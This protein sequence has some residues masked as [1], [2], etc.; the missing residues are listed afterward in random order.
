MEALKLATLAPSLTELGMEFDVLLQ[1]YRHISA[2]CDAVIAESEK[3][4]ALAGVNY[5]SHDWSNRRFAECGAD[6]RKANAARAELED[7]THEIA[8][9]PPSSLAD[10]LVK[11]KARLFDATPDEIL[12]DIL[13]LMTVTA[14]RT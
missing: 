2:Q 4:L 5:G 10:L 3:T 11:V 12:I 1:A 8:N 13:H 7:L 6:I 14:T 9:R